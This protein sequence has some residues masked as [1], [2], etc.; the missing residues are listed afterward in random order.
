MFSHAFVAALLSATATATTYPIINTTYGQLRGQASPYRDDVTEYLGIPYGAS[1]GGDN[2]WKA[3]QTTSWEGVLNATAFGSNCASPASDSA[4][5][6][7][8]IYNTSSEDC[9]FLNIWTPSD[10]SAG[11]LPVYFWIYGGRFEGGDGAVPTY[12]GAGLAS[13][14]IIVVTINYRLGAFGYLAHPDLSAESGHNASGN[15]GLLDQQLALTWV[16]ENIE[17]FGGNASQITVGGQSAGSACALDTIYSPLSRD[18]V[19]GVISESGARTPKD[20]L[21]GSLASSYRTKAAAEAD[22]V[23]FLETMNVSSIAELRNVST[24][25]LI[26]QGNLMDT[27]FDDTIYANLTSAFMDPPLWRPVIDGYVL[28]LGYGEALASNDH[29]DVPVLTGGNKDESGASTAPGFTLETFKSDFAEAFQN[30]STEFFELYPA[31][32]DDDA[33]NAN[34]ALFDDLNRLSVWLWGQ[35]WTAGGASSN[36]YGYYWYHTPAED[37]DQGAYH[38]SELWYNFNNIPYASYSN[39]TWN[40]TDY[41][42]EAVMAQYWANF[43]KTGNPNGGNLSQWP[44]LTTETQE[45]MWLGDSFESSWLTEASNRTTFLESWLDTL[46]SY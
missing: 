45:I 6:L 39:V 35:A 19:A 25:D 12:N 44:A 13:K 38:G 10:T 31:A 43:I 5:V 26:A 46:P 22:G 40:Q 1:T 17:N 4:S 24:E 7:G 34:N 2:R 37:Q 9:L 33:N 16:Y 20:P 8:N 36:V 30:F 27:T 28:P 21:I 14:D 23:S 11:N 42:I 29:A 41:E 32:S 3:P 18:M 15:Y